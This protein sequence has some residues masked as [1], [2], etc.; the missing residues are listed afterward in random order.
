[1]MLGNF[2]DGRGTIRAM[3][4]HTNP[5]PEAESWT[6]A[7]MYLYDLACGSWAELPEEYAQNRRFCAY[8]WGSSAQVPEARS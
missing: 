6:E 3:R 2:T 4:H 8:S 7:H 1:M 5:E